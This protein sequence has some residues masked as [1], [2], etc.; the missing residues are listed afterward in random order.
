M[1][2]QIDGEKLNNHKRTTY[3]LLKYDQEHFH[4]LLVLK[5]HHA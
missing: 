1:H 3:L 2:D 4:C 5:E